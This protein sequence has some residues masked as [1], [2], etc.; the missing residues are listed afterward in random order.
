MKRLLQY[1]AFLA[2]ILL[3][4]LVLSTTAS[5][6]QADKVRD[7][8]FLHISHGADA[9]HRLLMALKMAVTMAEGDRDVLVYCDIEAVKVLTKDAE[10][11]T[12]EPFPSSVEL[13]SRLAELKV[14]VLACPTC[15]KVAHVEA[16]ALRAGVQVA[17][18]DLFFSFTK[19]RILSLDY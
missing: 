10:A 18:R 8:V 1:S 13:L 3:S 11:V 15:M 17:Q 7:G 5:A 14:K 6:Q 12:F 9:P 16:S 4:S 19:G 2:V